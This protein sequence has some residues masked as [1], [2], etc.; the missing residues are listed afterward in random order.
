[1]HILLLKIK[2]S[3]AKFDYFNIGNSF[4]IYC[5]CAFG[6]L[7]ILLTIFPKSEFVTKLLASQPFSFFPYYFLV[8]F[9]ALCSFILGFWLFYPNRLLLRTRSIWDY[10]WESKRLYWVFGVIFLLGLTTKFIR[11]KEGG[12]YYLIRNTTLTNH[13][14]YSILGLFDWFGLIALVISL[15]AYFEY[16]RTNNDEL[17]IFRYLVWLLITIEILYAFISG[18][19]GPVLVPIVAYLLVR[20]Y[21]LRR[22]AWITLVA[23]L[24]LFFIGMTF[25]NINRSPGVFIREY[26]FIDKEGPLSL[27]EAAIERGESPSLSIN[28]RSWIFMNYVLGSS[29]MRVDQSRLLLAILRYFNE[30]TYGESIKKFFISLGPP[31]FIWRDKPIIQNDISYLT[32]IAGMRQSNDSTSISATVIGDWYMNFA[33]PGV[34]LGM[35]LMGMLFKILSQAFIVPGNVSLTGL[36]LFTVTWLHSIPSSIEGWMAPLWAG[37][38]KLFFIMFIIHLALR[39]FPRTSKKA[40][41]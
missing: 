5:L 19:R 31:R 26:N 34:I 23:F 36:M 27:R 4:I 21:A 12:F 9:I 7:P 13:P 10:K 30:F 14:L 32:K 38:V 16:L 6:A 40:V 33:L 20:H 24:I 3:V 37:Y 28:R 2:N 8:V 11:V 35:F 22:S 15:V 25:L 17:R 41:T 29:I 1:M 18:S 39:G